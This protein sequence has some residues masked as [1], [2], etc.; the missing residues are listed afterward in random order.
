MTGE[1]AFMGQFHLSFLF[2]ENFL[3]EKVPRRGTF[4]GFLS[5]FSMVLE[6]NYSVQTQYMLLFSR[7]NQYIVVLEGA[8]L[9]HFCFKALPLQLKHNDAGTPV[10]F[11]KISTA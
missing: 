2:S 6:A 7:D 11:N 1:A 3:L 9:W 10:E 5:P 8:T 4:L